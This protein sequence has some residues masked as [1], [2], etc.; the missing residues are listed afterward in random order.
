M[1]I[2]NE[3]LNTSDRLPQSVDQEARNRLVVDFQAA[4]GVTLGDFPLVLA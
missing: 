1:Y 4:D 3:E 2:A